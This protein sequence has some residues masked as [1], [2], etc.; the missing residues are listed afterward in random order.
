MDKLLDSIKFDAYK[1]LDLNKCSLLSLAL[2][3]VLCMYGLSLVT[4]R[5]YFDPLA[6]FPGPKIAAAT[7]CNHELHRRRR[8]PLEPF[9]SR[10]GIDKMESMIIE[11][12]QLLNTRMDGLK[13]SKSVI[14]LD[15]VFSA[16]AGDVIGRICCETPPNMMNEASFGLQWH[17]L[18]EGIVR[19]LLLF[20][21]IPQLVT[22]ARMIPTELLFRVYPG[23]AGFNSFRK[24]AWQHIEDSKRQ[25]LSPEKVDENATS[26]IFRHIVSGDMP[27]SE[28]SVE[29]LSREAM[30]L[31]GAG[32]ATTA[33]TMGFMSYYIL[34]NPHMRKRLGNELKDIMSGYPENPPKW[35]DLEKL[36]Y[37]QAIIKEGLRYGVMRRLPRCSPDVALQY[38]QWTIPRNTPVGMGAYM[39]HTDPD[40]YTEP[41]KFIPERWL[42]DYDPKMNRNWVPFT[43]GSRNCLGI[44]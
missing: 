17:D 22:L 41:F 44:K 2:V 12:A 10:L 34:R 18:I 43:R 7:G 5:L 23:A 11:E 1:D 6:G 13:G 3:V 16:F 42:G 29:R 35:S 38:K 32:T 24:L 39:M 27:E 4:Y 21:Q 30:V 25:N 19:Q 8:K 14:R 20:M 33:R 31:F 9:F 40:V 26:S 15:H 36:P 28:R 37:L